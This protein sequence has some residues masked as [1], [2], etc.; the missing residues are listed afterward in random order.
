MHLV[1]TNGWEAAIPTMEA[2]VMVDD[3]SAFAWFCWEGQSF[4]RNPKRIWTEVVF[5]MDKPFI[6]MTALRVSPVSVAVLPGFIKFCITALPQLFGY[7]DRVNNSELR[8][9]QA[10]TTISSWGRFCE[11]C[12]YSS[13]LMMKT[14]W[15]LALTR[16]HLVQFIM[17]K[18][19][20]MINLFLNTDCMQYHKY[21]WEIR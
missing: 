1:I 12:K 18:R 16:F 10:L 19:G 15:S 3:F 2:A 6:S 9:Y 7:V 14:L 8:I 11:W 21:V 5:P 4:D 17:P 13:T 20:S